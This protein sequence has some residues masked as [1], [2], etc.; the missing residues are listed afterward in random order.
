VA[1]RVSAL[2][3]TGG[4]NEKPQE[5]MFQVADKISSTAFYIAADDW[6]RP[7]G[8]AWV[9]GKRFG[10]FK[11]AVD[12]VTDFLEISH[13]RCFYEIIRKDRPCK[14]YLDLEADAGAITEVEGQAMRDAVIREW[15][16]R[17]ERRWPEVGIQSARRFTHMILRGSS[18]TAGGLKISYHV[19]YPF[20]VFPCNTTMLQDEVGSMSKMQQ[21]QYRSTQT[22]ELK[23]FI[24]PGV[25][26]SN[27][28]FRLLLCTKLSDC[29]MTALHLSFPPTISQFVLS[30]ITHLDETAWRVQLDVIPSGVSEVVGNRL[31][32]RPQ[33]PKATGTVPPA[34]V[35]LLTFLYH[36]LH[37]QG[38]PRGQLHL[39]GDQQD[40][41]RFRWEVAT[42]T[43]R[44]CMTAQ[45]W[46]PSLAGHHSNGAWIM[47]NQQGAVHLLCLHPQ[48]LLRGYSNKRL[49]GQTPLWLMPLIP[50]RDADTTQDS[51]EP[52]VNPHHD[53]TRSPVL[54]GGIDR[55]GPGRMASPKSPSWRE[56]VIS[57]QDLPQSQRMD[58]AIPDQGIVI[59]DGKRGP[60]SDLPS[61]C[62][63][64]RENQNSQ[65]SH[66][67]SFAQVATE[68]HG[69]LEVSFQAWTAEPGS[70]GGRVPGNMAALDPA[71][72]SSPPLP[73]ELSL[74]EWVAS[75]EQSPF[76]VPPPAS[77]LQSVQTLLA[78]D[79]V[80]Q[81][82]ENAQARLDACAG[83]TSLDSTTDE[84]L[85]SH[86]LL[87]PWSVE[88]TPEW[89]QSSL[90]SRPNLGGALIERA[91]ALYGSAQRSQEVQHHP[92]NLDTWSCPFTVCCLN[93]GLRHLVGS[94][95]NCWNWSGLSGLIYSFLETW[96]R[97]A[98]RLV[99]SKR[100]GKVT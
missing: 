32:R 14:A 30:C 68:N 93:V 66:T 26:T 46:R 75:S 76:V 3:S 57:H 55:G 100:N 25:Y 79:N 92:F 67:Q 27:R 1:Y 59:E 98:I 97:P 94:N 34:L 78:N 84:S 50:L 64:S 51:G 65:L 81:A 7:H 48:C 69:G 19:I 2:E 74:I 33:R 47:I 62:M 70:W 20:L 42:G 49:L 45:I 60:V 5:A 23:S 61:Y 24:D 22:G 37:T 35:P 73:P 6:T 96:S 17:V 36:L 28:Q 39:A 95:L 16:A 44:P 89:F 4:W 53:S 77:L 12:F 54:G 91:I 80:R 9:V 8:K 52:P 38:Q 11:N 13:N 63:D 82:Q 58:A 88:P 10:A 71:S 21:F 43:L 72:S 86:E 56:T 29:T 87:Q 83:Q 41:L 90:G 99:G 31:Q 15:R 85:P 40:G 18:M